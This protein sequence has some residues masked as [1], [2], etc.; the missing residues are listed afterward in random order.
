MATTRWFKLFPDQA[1]G[2]IMQIFLIKFVL[3]T[4]ARIIPE[5]FIFYSI[6]CT[7]LMGEEINENMKRMTKKWEKKM[8][9][10]IKLKAYRMMSIPTDGFMMTEILMSIKLINAKMKKK[11]ISISG[12][13]SLLIFSYFQIFVFSM[14]KL[15]LFLGSENT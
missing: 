9:N 12:K 6:L 14:S 7:L 4:W 10:F 5:I 15:N 3:Q 13:F 1:T 11:I 2:N 8:R